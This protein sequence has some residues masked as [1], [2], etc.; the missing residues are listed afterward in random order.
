MTSDLCTRGSPTPGFDAASV[1]ALV[2]ALGPSWLY[3]AFQLPVY[4]V[5]K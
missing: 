4:T 5:N 1:P 3:D 2:P